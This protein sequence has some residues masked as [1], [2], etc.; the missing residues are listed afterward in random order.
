[1]IFGYARVSTL[2]QNLDRQMDQLFQENCDRI[3]SDKLSGKNTERPELEKLLDQIRPGDVIIVTELSRISRSTKDL[4]KLVEF[5]DEKGTNLKSL[6]EPWADTT[7]PYGNLMFTIFAGINQFERDLISIRTREGLAAAKA[8][9][10]KGGRP[11]SRNKKA[12]LIILLYKDGRKI[13]DIM[14]ETGLSRTTVNNYIR[15]YKEK[16]YNNESKS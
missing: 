5:L 2:D 15:E 16:E 10:R 12:D 8:R 7:T 9:G 3:F 4:F 14:E 11:K 6:K 13:K 1:M